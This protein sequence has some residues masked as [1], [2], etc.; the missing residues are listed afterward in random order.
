MT[1]LMF[2]RGRWIKEL[3]WDPGEV[4]VP[5]EP[6]V[7]DTFSELTSPRAASL[8]DIKERGFNVVVIQT[9]EFGTNVYLIGP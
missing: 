9:S 1:H 3:T 6:V 4:E 8:R 7:G 5:R 2:K